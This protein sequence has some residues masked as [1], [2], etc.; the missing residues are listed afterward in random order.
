MQE[1]T[2]NPDGTWP[3]GQSGNPAGVN[4]RARGW[5]RYGERVQKWLDMPIKDLLALATDEQAKSELSTIDAI[6]V[7]HIANSVTG[8]QVLPERKELLDR[9]EG[10]PKQVIDLTS[11]PA[12][13]IAD[14]ATPEQLQE[15][16]AQLR[17][18]A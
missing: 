9:I 13:K 15:A 2:R 3:R 10:A 14:D 7:Q 17:Q 16:M 5:Q 4:N 12:P 18:Q 8:K 11:R 1:M 6:C